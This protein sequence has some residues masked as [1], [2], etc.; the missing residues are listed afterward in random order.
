MDTILAA[1]EWAEAVDLNASAITH[2]LR[3]TSGRD[4][5]AILSEREASLTRI[6]ELVAAHPVASDYPLEARRI[7]DAA[8]ELL[9]TILFYRAARDTMSADAARFFAYQHAATDREAC[10]TLCEDIYKV[11]DAWRAAAS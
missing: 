6:R 3:H 8:V 5:P 2:H 9:R 11:A 4:L 1:V 10:R 7:D